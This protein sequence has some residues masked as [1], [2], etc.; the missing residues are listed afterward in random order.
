MSS[1]PSV[2]SAT[3]SS[4]T[5]PFS[6]SRCSSPLSRARSV[7]GRIGRKRSALSAVAL[8]RGSTTISFAPADFTR[9]IIRRKRIG[10]QSA[11]LE[12]ITRNT[13]AWS[14]SRYEPGGPSA[15]SDSL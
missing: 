14:R 4:S 13:S 2:N 9:S 5:C 10:W 1:Q 12:P 6:T 15:P 11:M 7:P 3:N 8:R